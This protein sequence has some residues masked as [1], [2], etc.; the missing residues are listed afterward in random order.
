[1]TYD[2][3]PSEPDDR[4][5]HVRAASGLSAFKEYLAVM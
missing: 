1:M 3:G 2:E 4:P 5:P